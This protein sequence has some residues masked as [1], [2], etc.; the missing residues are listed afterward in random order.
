MI[1][2]YGAGGLKLAGTI[3]R[4][5]LVIFDDVARLWSVTRI[6]DATLDSIL[7]LIAGQPEIILLGCGAKTLLPPKPLRESA[8]MSGVPLETMDTGA[9]CRTYNILMNE[10]RRV[11][12]ALLA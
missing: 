7:D 5:P 1:E 2:G 3:Y 4:P 10:G 11:A 12:A 6:E 9:A 8:R